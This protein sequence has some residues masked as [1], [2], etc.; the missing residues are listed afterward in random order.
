MA[1][2]VGLERKKQ[3]EVTRPAQYQMATIELSPV[4]KFP[5]DCGMKW[6]NP[7]ELMLRIKDD[8]NIDRV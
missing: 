8:R 2:E 6:L 4:Q 1:R 3:N 5:F 7:R